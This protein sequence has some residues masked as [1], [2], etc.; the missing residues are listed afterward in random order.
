ML[1]SAFSYHPVYYKFD[2]G[3]DKPPINYYEYGPQNSRG[4]RALK[5]W[6]A[7]QQVGRQGYI[8]MITEDCNLATKL[9]DLA[10]E[11]PELEA[12]T[13][14]L[15]ITT[16]RYIPS[17]LDPDLQAAAAYLNELNSELLT[18]LQRGGEIFLS[19]A[20]I[21]DKYALRS[22]VVNF[23]T[24]LT[25]IQAIPQIV[26]RVGQELDSQIRPAALQSG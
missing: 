1:I 6:L 21:Q 22:C 23:R 3:I 18:L 12:M 20:L 17:D 26:T 7:L 16:F 9:Y 8:Q 10:D 4:F 25:D 13:V 24:T 5:V 15:S 2:E 14:N 19:N 11:H